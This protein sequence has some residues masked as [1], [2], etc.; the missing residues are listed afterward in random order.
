MH[1]PKIIGHRGCAGLFPENS[2]AACRH[3]IDLG[4]DG[5]EIDVQL[6]ADGEIVVYH[7]FTINNDY[8]QCNDTWADGNGQAIKKLTYAELSSYTIGLTRPR[9]TYRQRRRGQTQL[10]NE[11]IP[12]LRQVFSLLQ[13]TAPPT[14]R[15]WLEIKTHPTLNNLSADPMELIDK[16]IDLMEHYQNH[17]HIVIISFDWRCLTYVRQHY[18]TLR[19]GFLTS[20][21]KDD[22]TVGRCNTMPSPW[23]GSYNLDDYNGSLP[24]LI[25]AVGGHYWLPSYQDIMREDVITAHKLS[26]PVYVWTVNTRSFMQRLARWGVDGLITDY[27]NK[28]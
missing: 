23:L 28:W 1:R 7:D 6:S 25:K 8:S 20:E 17:E 5:I 9:S 10:A 3:A 12:T 4:L 13:D 26:L 21:H 14:F 24:H 15:L 22:D 16:I 19:C 27:P 11:P 2:L 18:P